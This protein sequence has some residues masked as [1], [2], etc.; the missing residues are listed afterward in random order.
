MSP[1]STTDRECQDCEVGLTFKPVT[2]SVAI[3]ELV[4]TRK[5][6]PADRCTC[7]RHSSPAHT[8]LAS[9]VGLPRPVLASLSLEEAHR[10][11]NADPPLRPPWTCHLDASAT[12]MRSYMHADAQVP[13]RSGG[14]PSTHCLDRPCLRSDTH[15]DDASG[16][17]MRCLPAGDGVPPSTGETPQP[18]SPQTNIYSSF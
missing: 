15:H 10:S 18:P 13:R 8:H 14:N 2:G 5:R 17:P 11:P 16:G 6:L 4:S 3:C 1:T 9:C 12:C 7:R